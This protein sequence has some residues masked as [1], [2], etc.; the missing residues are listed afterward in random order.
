MILENKTR[1]KDFQDGTEVRKLQIPEENFNIKKIFLELWCFVSSWIWK[2]YI[3][4]NRVMSLIL[5][6][7]RNITSDQKKLENFKSPQEFYHCWQCWKQ[8][9]HYL[10]RSRKQKKKH[11]VLMSNYFLKNNWNKE[12]EVLRCPRQSFHRHEILL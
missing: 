7:V 6:K 8:S 3:F 9:I 4:W 2:L 5:A 1:S 12:H 10:L 11:F